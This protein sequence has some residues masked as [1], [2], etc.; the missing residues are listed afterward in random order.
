MARTTLL[1]PP[2]LF[3]NPARVC[4][5]LINHYWP[6]WNGSPPSRVSFLPWIPATYVFLFASPL[7]LNS[8]LLEVKLA[9]LQM[10]LVGPFPWGWLVVNTQEFYFSVSLQLVGVIS[11]ASNIRMEDFFKQS[12]WSRPRLGWKYPTLLMKCFF[13][14]R[15]K[16]ELKRMSCNVYSREFHFIMKHVRLGKRMTFYCSI[17]HPGHRG[18]YDL[19]YEYKKTPFLNSTLSFFG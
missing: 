19:S 3:P 12:T 6:W 7:S 8:R 9:I 16:N 18:C 11:Y 5:D 17:P 2:P 13:C 10:S 4:R 1:S 14:G 15:S